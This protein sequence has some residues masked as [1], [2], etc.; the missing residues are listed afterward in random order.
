MIRS[1]YNMKRN[2]ILIHGGEEDFNDGVPVSS[3]RR[4]IDLWWGGFKGN[5]GLMMILVYMLQNSI[6]WKNADVHLKIIVELEDAVDEIR[7]NMLAIVN[8]IRFD[9]EIDIIIS[10]GRPFPEIF[11]QSSKDADLILLGMANPGK[12]FTKYYENMLLQS[13]DMPTTVFVLAGQDISFGEVLIP[14]DTMV[15]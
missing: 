12:D 13:E 5:G 4:K 9:A 15:D 11:K 7:N 3:K 14:K 8:Q 6:S 10:N 2:V 1:F